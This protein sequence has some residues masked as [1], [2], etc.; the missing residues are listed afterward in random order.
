MIAAFP[1]LTA[2]VIV[3]R[4]RMGRKRRHARQV[5][6]TAYIRECAKRATTNKTFP[7]LTNGTASQSEEMRKAAEMPEATGNFTQGSSAVEQESHNLHAAG[8]IPAPA[9]VPGAATAPGLLV[10]AGPARG[11]LGSPRTAGAEVGHG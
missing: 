9:S 10:E 6:M 11:V 8:S 2:E 4:M 1:T 3:A 5:V 7:R